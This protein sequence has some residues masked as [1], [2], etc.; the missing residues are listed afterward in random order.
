MAIKTGDEFPWLLDNSSINDARVSRVTT[1]KFT[2]SICIPVGSAVLV[3]SI[4][5][6]LEVILMLPDDEHA[7]RKR[8]DAMDIRDFI[9]GIASAASV[10]AEDWLNQTAETLP[11]G[12]SAVL[13]PLARSEDWL[14]QTAETLP[15]RLWAAAVLLP[16]PVCQLVLLDFQ[17]HGR[18]AL[19]LY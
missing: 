18:L 16:A 4:S 13:S 7:V 19:L 5:S 6:G 10:E 2:G 8:I 1:L 12:P 9:M 11:E 15:A 17:C 3:I 14:N